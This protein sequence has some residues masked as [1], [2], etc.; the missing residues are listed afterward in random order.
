[1]ALFLIFT[2]ALAPIKTF[3][4]SAKDEGIITSILFIEDGKQVY[5]E[6]ED[7][8]QYYNRMMSQEEVEN[9]ILEAR[10]VNYI[11]F[12]PQIEPKAGSVKY[13]Y[14]YVQTS[15]GKSKGKPVRVTQYVQNKSSIVQGIDV[16]LS[17][18]ISWSINAE[19]TGKLKDAVIGSLGSSWT[20]S[21]TASTT[22]KLNVAPKKQP[23][24][25]LRQL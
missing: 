24:L 1:M 19:V 3:A 15:N 22:I 16:S 7:A 4:L 6:G 25:N 14:Y 18:T 10:E 12:N 23:G 11:N 8:Q 21:Q 5:L 2:M 9:K 13:G 20:K 17:K